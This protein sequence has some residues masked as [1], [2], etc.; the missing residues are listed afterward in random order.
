M[1]R[2]LSAGTLLYGMEAHN[3]QAD[4]GIAFRELVWGLLAVANAYT[5]A[6]SDEDGAV[7]M[8]IT[9]AETFLQ[10]TEPED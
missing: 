10:A 2:K 3:W 6:N 5:P 8:L 1:N 9:D 7:R 4:S